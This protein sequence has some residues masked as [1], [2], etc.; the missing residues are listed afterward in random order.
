M[1]QTTA[2][3]GLWDTLNEWRAKIEGGVML[4]SVQMAYNSK[5]KAHY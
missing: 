5:Q 3:I 4:L 1:C 2:Y